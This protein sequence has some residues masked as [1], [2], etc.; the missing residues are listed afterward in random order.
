MFKKIKFILFA[1]FA[2]N[3]YAQQV[4]VKGTVVDENK[5]PIPGVNIVV[6]G[7]TSGVSTDIDGKFAISVQKNQTLVISSI[8]FSNKEIVCTGQALGT[9]VLTTSASTLDEIIVTGV[10]K[11]TSVKK[12]G[13]SIEKLTEKQLKQVPANDA[14]TAMLGKMPGVKLVPRGGAPGSGF[15]VQLRG[16]KSI[17]GGSSPLIIIDG[18]LGAELNISSD[19]IASIEVLKGAAASSLY[20]SRAANGVV[21]ITT[22]RG[23]SLAAGNVEVNVRSEF[24]QNTLGFVPEQSKSTNRIINNGVV[25]TNVSPD[26]IYDNLYPKTYDHVNQFFNPGGFLTNYIG[27]RGNS[28]D[29]KLSMYASVQNSREEGI[30][31]MVDGLERNNLKLNLDYK[32]LP[33]LTLK[34]SNFHSSFKTE[35]VQGDIFGALLRSDPNADLNLPNADGSPYLVNVNTFSDG[36]VNPLY[37]ISKTKNESSNKM[38]QS[39]FSLVYDF[40]NELKFIASY[41]SIR[42]NG[43]SFYMQP[44]G[45]LNYNLVEGNGYIARSMYENVDK[46]ISFDGAYTKTFGNFNTVTKAQFLY[47]SSDYRDISGSASNLALGGFDLTTLNA[48]SIPSVNSSIVLTNAYNYSLISAVDYKGK[49]IFDGLIRRDASSLF[50]P[51]VRWQ[52]FYR[53]SGAWRITEDFKINGI[54]EWKFRTSYGT[55]GLRPPY[56]AIYETFALNQGVTGSQETLGNSNLKPSFS[57]EWEIGTDISFLKKFTMSLNYSIANN[58]DLILK[59]PVSP[60]SGAA[61]QWQN[62][63]AMKSNTFEASLNYNVLSNKDWNL[64]LRTTFDTYTQTVTKLNATPYFIDGTRFIIK[65]GVAFGTLLLDKFAHSLDEVTNQVPAG[66]SVNDIFVINNQGYVVK[67]NTIGTTAETPIKVTDDKGIALPVASINTTPDFTMNFNTTLSYKKFTF[68]TLWSWQQGGYMYNHSVR[69]QTEPKLFDQSGKP[70]NEVKSS[71][72]YANGGQYSGLLGWDNDALVYDATFV[73][74]REVSLSYD[75]KIDSWKFIQN[76]RFNLIGRNLLTLTEYPGF[77]P[78]TGASQGGVDASTFKFDSN[79]RY[80]SPRLISGAL[81]I[82]F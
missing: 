10:A 63:A 82:T 41:G 46:N 55:A 77:D 3:M 65:E 17:T 47:E 23:S 80:P 64:D 79:N 37:T 36:Q 62:A 39:F 30:V 60:L 15:D 13:F 52:N 33:N 67:R 76:I 7:T 58:T 8:G 26:Q 59:V 71:T 40:S 54:D 12:L 74:L 75:F 11:G 32:I 44:K 5:V 16:A 18:V 34:T 29:N 81:T 53:L 35:G 1:L 6:K 38:L 25:T 20:G 22:K 69:Y 28:N 31:K 73:K 4:S 50:G 48:G 78:E 19:D 51:D 2:I 21:N 14:A 56:G 68:Y 42:S 61:F 27:I 57:K 24:G 66:S 9:I 72:Y 49:Y 43:S 70:S 45:M